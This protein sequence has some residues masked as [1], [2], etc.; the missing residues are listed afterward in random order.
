[1]KNHN[2]INNISSELSRLVTCLGP[3]PTDPRPAEEAYDIY[4]EI[5]FARN[6]RATAL[7]AVCY[8]CG[9]NPSD[10]LEHETNWA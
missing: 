5:R 4:S 1:M 2:M 6:R 3:A 7:A 9:L 10:A 8:W